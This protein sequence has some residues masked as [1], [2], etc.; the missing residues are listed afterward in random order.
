MT[1]QLLSELKYVTDMVWTLDDED[2]W[3]ALEQRR[4][5]AHAL[6]TYELKHGRKI[7][8][9]CGGRELA[10]GDAVQVGGRSFYVTGVHHFCG[11]S[12]AQVRPA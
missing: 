6:P 10:K 11:G 5:A 9:R 12:R 3:V 4:Q 8:G 2:A 7:V 1:V